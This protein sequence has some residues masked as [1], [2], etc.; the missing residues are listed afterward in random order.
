MT[1]D[2]LHRFISIEI[3][4]EDNLAHF[5]ECASQQVAGHDENM[6]LCLAIDCSEELWWSPTIQKKLKD[7]EFL[8]YKVGVVCKLLGC[9]RVTEDLTNGLKSILASP[10]SQSFELTKLLIRLHNGKVVDVKELLLPMLRWYSPIRLW[11]TAIGTFRICEPS[12]LSDSKFMLAP[13]LRS[14]EV[15]VLLNLLLYDIKQ[16]SEGARFLLVK[17]VQGLRRLG[18]KQHLSAIM[19]IAR[20]CAQYNLKLAIPLMQEML[21]NGDSRDL[22]HLRLASH[23]NSTRKP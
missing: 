7:A 14:D 17:G 4:T 5:I 12:V 3:S 11:A 19:R 8:N 18:P 2:Q 13:R 23:L 10:L 22:D 16:D 6:V 21:A 9:K 15:R 1:T 20:L